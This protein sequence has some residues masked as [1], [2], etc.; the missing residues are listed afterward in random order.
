MWP[1]TKMN[2]YQCDKGMSTHRYVWKMVH[3][4]DNMPRL[5][6]CFGTI[7]LPYKGATNIKLILRTLS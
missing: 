3:N 7:M 6:T 2:A 1:V 5:G 4:W